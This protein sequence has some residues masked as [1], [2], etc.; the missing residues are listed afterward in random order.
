MDVEDAIHKLKSLIETT[1]KLLT[2]KVKS[3]Q[4][5]RMKL[6]ETRGTLV[7]LLNSVESTMRF[8]TKQVRYLASIQRFVTEQR[9]IASESKKKSAKKNATRPE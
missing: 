6:Q 7:S 5:N 8:S 4:F 9:T 2:A 3:E 1:D